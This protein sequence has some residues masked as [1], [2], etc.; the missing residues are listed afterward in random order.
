[1]PVPT[2]VVSIHVCEEA[3]YS[4]KLFHLLQECPEAIQFLWTTLVKG[5]IPWGT[6]LKRTMWICVLHNNIVT[7]FHVSMKILQDI[8]EVNVSVVNNNPRMRPAQSAFLPGRFSE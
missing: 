6:E 1:M 4:I 3:V 7:L 2:A 5:G 8:G